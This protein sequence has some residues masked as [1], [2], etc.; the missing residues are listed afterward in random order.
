MRSSIFHPKHDFQEN[1]FAQPDQHFKA[2]VLK[3]FCWLSYQCMP[4]VSLV[5]RSTAQKRV[6]QKVQPLPWG[7]SDVVMTT[8]QPRGISAFRRSCDNISENRYF[9]AHP[10]TKMYTACICALLLPS[11][12]RNIPSNI[13]RYR[14]YSGLRAS[15][16]RAEQPL[17]NFLRK[18]KDAH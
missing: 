14:A 6:S 13:F 3:P 8:Y 10:K 11:E 7:G 5:R 1:S 17:W 9:R 2:L 12:V 18:Q 15:H 4:W 16:D